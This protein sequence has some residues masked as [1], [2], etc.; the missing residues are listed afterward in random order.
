[1]VKTKNKQFLV[2]LKHEDGGNMRKV[3]L[4]SNSQDYASINERIDKGGNDY[5]DYVDYTDYSNGVQGGDYLDELY[6]D[7]NWHPNQVLILSVKHSVNVFS[8]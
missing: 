2:K 1:M 6:V 3:P 8:I 7:E 5:F 4:T